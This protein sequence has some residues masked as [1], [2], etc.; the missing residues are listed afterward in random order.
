MKTRLALSILLVLLA[1][2]GMGSRAG[3]PASDG[4]ASGEVNSEGWREAWP[5]YRFTF[6]RDHAAHEPYRIEW[7]YYTGNLQSKGGRRFGF[8]LTFFRTGVSPEPST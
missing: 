1:L 4:P 3:V 2:T 5:G 6:P 7:W 8:Q